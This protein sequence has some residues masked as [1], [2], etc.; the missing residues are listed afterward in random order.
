MANRGA[1][2]AVAVSHDEG[3]WWG[4]TAVKGLY[5]SFALKEAR[6]N[7]DIRTPH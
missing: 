2:A 4:W 1:G 5:V 3:L 7:R 6:V